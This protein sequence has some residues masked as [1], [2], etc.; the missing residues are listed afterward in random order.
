MTTVVQ[1]ANKIWG[2]FGGINRGWLPAQ[3]GGGAAVGLAGDWARAPRVGG[4]VDR[5]GI[6]VTLVPLSRRLHPDRRGPRGEDIGGA[7]FLRALKIREES[8]GPR[9][10]KTANILKASARLHQATSDY[11]RTEM[12]FSQAA[13]IFQGDRFLLPGT[14]PTIDTAEEFCRPTQWR[15][16]QGLSPKDC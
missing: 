2:R 15:P 8:L 14:Y 3:S 5:E 4:E 7:P 10:P 12:S 16:D 1:A 6:R 13:D 11:A 9:H